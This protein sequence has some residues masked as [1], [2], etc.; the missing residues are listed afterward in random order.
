[1]AKTLSDR[2]FTKKGNAKAF[3]FFV[4]IRHRAP[5]ASYT[6]KREWEHAAGKKKKNEKNIF[7]GQGLFFLLL[8]LILGI[9]SW[10]SPTIEEKLSYQARV[11][12]TAAVN[13]A[14]AEELERMG[15]TYH[16]MVRLTR[17]ELGK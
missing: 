9:H 16:Q 11:L 14:V 2:I 13:Q 10:I 3:S 5:L 17:M 4:K 7:P 15:V 1:M 8:S 6:E 12:V